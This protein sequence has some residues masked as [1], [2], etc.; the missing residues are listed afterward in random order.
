MATNS[1]ASA[2]NGATVVITHHVHPGKESAYESWLSEIGPLCRAAPGHLDVQI[3][4][5][6]PGITTTYTVII[7]FDTELHLRDWIESSE[8]QRLIERVRPSLAADDDYTI[9]SGLDFW[10][11]PPASGAKVPVR[12]KQFLLTWSAIYPLVL[13]VPPLMVQLLRAIGFPENR[14]LGTLL[15]AG[16]MVALMVYVIMPHYT[17]LVRHWLF[18]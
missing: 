15:V 9:R 8:R 6:I 18:E 14:F 12:W 17:R 13:V 11:N 2:S 10:F 5:P 16:V 3:I 1:S 4:R 7:R